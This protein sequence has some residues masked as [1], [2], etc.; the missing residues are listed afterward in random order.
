MSTHY[1]E[2]FWYS[3]RSVAASGG[4]G[5]RAAYNLCCKGGRIVLPK[6]MRWS[7]PLDELAVFGAGAWSTE[8]MRLIGSHNSLFV[9]T[10]LWAKENYSASITILV[11]C[12]P[13]AFASLFFHSILLFCLKLSTL[14]ELVYKFR[15]S[16][17]IFGCF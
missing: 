6:F 9:F 8:F 1:G 5:Q 2:L 7:S 15:H 3:E 10:S 4:V 13:L 17:N 11:C 12:K 16:V 14:R